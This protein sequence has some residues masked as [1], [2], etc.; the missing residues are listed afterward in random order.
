MD[1]QIVHAVQQ[2]T[3]PVFD[4]IMLVFTQFGEQTLFILIFALTYW[5]V[6]KKSA[7]KLMFAFMLS[8]MVNGLKVI[9]KR[10]RPFMADSTVIGPSTPASDYS[11]PSGHSQNYSVVA[12]SFGFTLFGCT[13]KTWK[14]VAYVVG[15]VVMGICMGI[16]RIYFGMHYLTDVVAGLTLGALSALICELV[17]K[18]IPKKLKEFGLERILLIGIALATVA[19]VVLICIGNN[20]TG[21]YKDITLFIGLSAGHI[22][23]ERFI[24]YD[25]KKLRISKWIVAPFGILICGGAY[26]LLLLI[27]HDTVAISLAFFVVAVLITTFVPFMTVVAEKYFYKNDSARYND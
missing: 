24:R 25:P 7:I 6:D 18:H 20:T 16:S 17:S 10:D 19:L 15:A 22:V 4:F 21:L 23:N 11:F 8:L 1:L 14:R 13:K 27:P 3:S 26:A 5:C 2:L 9:V 12:T